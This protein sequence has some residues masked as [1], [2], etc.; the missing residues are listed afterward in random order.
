MDHLCSVAPAEPA[1]RAVNIITPAKGAAME[2]DGFRMGILSVSGGIRPCI[3]GQWRRLMDIFPYMHPQT[4][5]LV[6]IGIRCGVARQVLALAAL[7]RCSDRVRAFL[8]I[9]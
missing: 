6:A 7:E 3:R 4:A 9:R 2:Q 5:A 8:V 1:D